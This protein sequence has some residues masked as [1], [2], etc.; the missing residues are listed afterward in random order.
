MKL[1]SEK[2]CHR[3]LEDVFR[4]LLLLLIYGRIMKK[5]TYVKIYIVNS[6]IINL[7]QNRFLQQ[8]LKI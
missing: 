3:N 4:L 2:F 7:K 5:K 8:P 6:M 1:T